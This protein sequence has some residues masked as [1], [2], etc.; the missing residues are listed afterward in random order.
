MP[1]HYNKLPGIDH[2]N[3]REHADN[4]SPFNQG[5]FHGLLWKKDKEQPLREHFYPAT[6]GKHKTKYTHRFKKGKTKTIT[7]KF[8]TYGKFS[9]NT[10]T[11]KVFQ[12][13][14]MMKKKQKVKKKSN[15]RKS[16]KEK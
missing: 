12:D 4:S 14:K 9:T 6:Q 3:K 15:Y 2:G 1:S 5:V 7:N 8:E 16:V 11:S 10:T 13:G